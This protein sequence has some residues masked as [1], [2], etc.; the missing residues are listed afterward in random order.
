[1]TSGYELYP[2][3]RNSPTRTFEIPN[4]RLYVKMVKFAENGATIVGGSDHGC[5]YIFNVSE[6]DPV[7]VLYHERADC[8]VQTIAVS[9]F[10]ANG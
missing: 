6:S 8:M 7:Q 9:L 2:I 10:L 1:M 4:E 5:V 3:H